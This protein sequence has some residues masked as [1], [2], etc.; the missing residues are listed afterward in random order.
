MKKAHIR[1]IGKPILVETRKELID[2]IN[3]KY[4]LDIK[5]ILSVVEDKKQP[6]WYYIDYK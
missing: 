4:N 6:N 3:K 5:E 1:H 2:I